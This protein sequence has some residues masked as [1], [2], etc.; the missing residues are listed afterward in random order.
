MATSI[1]RVR[2]D[3]ASSGG[4][5]DAPTSSAPLH[6]QVRFKDAYIIQSGRCDY[7][8]LRVWPGA[9]MLAAA[10][11]RAGQGLRTHIAQASRKQ[12][13]NACATL[14]AVLVAHSSLSSLFSLH[15]P[16]FSPRC[17]CASSVPV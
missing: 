1:K 3:C 14:V 12:N 17:T 13:V 5:K 9:E 6:L 11:H 16:V 10:M 7:T 8:G 4:D 15:Q 2:I